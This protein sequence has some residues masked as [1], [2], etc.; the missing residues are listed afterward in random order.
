MTTHASIYT[1]DIIQLYIFVFKMNAM[2]WIRNY[3]MSIIAY[4]LQDS[5]TAVQDIHRLY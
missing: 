1:Y 2:T 4:T 5:R 3:C